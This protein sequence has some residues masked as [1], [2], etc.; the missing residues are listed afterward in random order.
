MFYQNIEIDIENTCLLHWS[1][2]VGFLL[3]ELEADSYERLKMHTLGQIDKLN[4]H[5]C[6][7]K[8][9]DTAFSKVHKVWHESSE[10]FNL[11]FSR[12]RT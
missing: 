5:I 10:R 7:L 2:S 9:T 1:M 4:L 11:V 6:D 12:G 8:I 3:A